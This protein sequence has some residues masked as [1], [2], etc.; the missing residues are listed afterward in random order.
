VIKIGPK[1]FLTGGRITKVNESFTVEKDAYFEATTIETLGGPNNAGPDIRWAAGNHQ[2]P[3]ISNGW[4]PERTGIHSDEEVV[5]NRYQSENGIR[6]V[7]LSQSVTFKQ[8][9]NLYVPENYSFGINTG[10][11]VTLNTDAVI[12]IHESSALVLYAASASSGNGAKLLGSGKV[13]VGRTE[14][15][16]G[17]EGWQATGDV[18]GGYVRIALEDSPGFVRYLGASKVTVIRPSGAE[19]LTGNAGAIITQ[20]VPNPRDP[21]LSPNPISP[22][23]SLVYD[24]SVLVIPQGV[25]VRLNAK[26]AI[27][28]SSDTTRAGEVSHVLLAVGVEEETVG[29][30]IVG[31]GSINAGNTVIKGGTGGWQ[32]FNFQDAL[33]G[34]L[35]NDYIII[36]QLDLMSARIEAWGENN[37]VS[38]GNG[39]P[40]NEATSVLQASAGATITQRAGGY[41]GRPNNLLI[42]KNTTIYLP[43]VGEITLEGR[44]ITPERKYPGQITFADG[45]SRIRFTEDP[46]G[47]PA[48]LI[49]SKDPVAGGANG[50]L[51]ATNYQG[52]IAFSG[53]ISSTLNPDYPSVDLP[54]SAVVQWTA[55]TVV[56]YTSSE[57]NELPVNT[58][59]E[60]GDARAEDSNFTQIQ[61]GATVEGL[62]SRDTNA[63]NLR[64]VRAVP[65]Q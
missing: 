23:P 33:V 44:L 25:T 51:G 38:I 14:I 7:G 40:D 16:G 11:T 13:S 3:F 5:F 1:G 37:R 6:Y 56:A 18:V 21:V 26:S 64:G 27:N 59:E 45:T 47:G 43:D 12:H 36:T 20:Q 46:L 53:L 54:E 60:L 24:Q 15:L 65:L 50:D 19:V 31:D 57:N 2:N 35:R 58:E 9:E 48:R 62:I 52:R 42:G 49:Y 4:L 41:I 28:L 32:A 22:L 34:A 63:V 17:E 29:A 61:G 30:R 8:R 10:V 55:R 39:T